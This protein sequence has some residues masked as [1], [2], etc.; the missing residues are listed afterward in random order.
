MPRYEIHLPDGK[1]I[2]DP[3]WQCV[4]DV[5]RGAHGQGVTRMPG[6]LVRVDDDA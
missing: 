3:S 5:M 1:V 2:R 6:E 4:A